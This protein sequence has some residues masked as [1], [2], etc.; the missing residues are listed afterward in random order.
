MAYLYTIKTIKGYD[1]N[2]YMV[3]D[4]ILK[5]HLGLNKSQ[6][7]VYLVFFHSKKELD[8]QEVMKILK[9]DR[10]TLQRT[11]NQF[12]EKGILEFKQVNLHKG[13]KYVYRMRNQE[14]EKQGWIDML[15]L[16]IEY[17]KSSKYHRG[18]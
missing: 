8:I 10:T 14:E 13:F 11:I 5:S 17:I 18:L 1:A 9:K 7:D 6:L 3:F 16:Q 15:E 4:R 2:Q 12:L